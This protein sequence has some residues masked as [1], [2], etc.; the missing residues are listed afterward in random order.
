MLYDRTGNRKYLTAKERRAFINAAEHEEAAN[1][2]FCLTLAYTGAR[3]SEVLA[4]TPRSFDLSVQGISI[5]SLKRR[6]R[7][8]FRTVPV[9]KSLLKRINVVHGV[10]ALQLDRDRRDQRIWPWC[11]T[12][13]WFRVTNVMK[14]AR[15]VGG[16][17]A[18]PKGLRHALAVEGVTEAGIALNI[19]QRWLGHARIETTAIYASA[20]G[21]EERALAARTWG[22]IK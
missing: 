3:I 10:T 22:K 6:K 11:R 8:V 14:K 4:L 12:T 20:V 16:P 2:T 19:I 15:V 5:E 21:R 13:A 18:V 17:W 7:G 1:A 9:P